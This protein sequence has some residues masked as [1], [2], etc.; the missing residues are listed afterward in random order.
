M[1]IIRDG[2]DAEVCLRVVPPTGTDLAEFAGMYYSDELEATW[3]LAARGGRLSVQ[4]L[5]DP[6]TDL[7]I[8][9]P[10]VFVTEQGVVVRFE[11]EGGRV[12]RAS[13]QAGRVTNL[14]FTR[15]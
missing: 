12:A 11:R 10:G 13:V 6:P 7:V 15:R 8:V 9:K 5:H 4:V 1:H 14:V 3:T 2:R